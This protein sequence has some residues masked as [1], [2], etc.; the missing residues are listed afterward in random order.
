MNTP[1]NRRAFLKLAGL[2][3]LAAG[4]GACGPVQSWLATATPV[5]P[6][7]WPTKTLA[8]GAETVD[9]TDVFGAH[10]DLASTLMRD[11][12]PRLVKD[13]ATAEDWQ[14][15]PL[16]RLVGRDFYGSLTTALE[17]FNGEIFS[18]G[19]DYLISYYVRSAGG[20][21]VY[22]WMH[23]LD[24]LSAYG[25]GPK[26]ATEQVRRVWHVARATGPNRL[27]VVRD[28]ARP[29][30]EQ[31]EPTLFWLFQG[32][33]NPGWQID[34]RVGGFLVED[35]GASGEAAP[36]SGVAVMG[37]STTEGFSGGTDHPL[38][39]E[40]TTH[41]AARLN[42]PFYNRAYHGWTTADMRLA[43][44]QRITPLA[45][46]CRFCIVQ[47]GLND[48]ALGRSLT[49]MQAD[50]QW[51]WNQAEALGMLPIVATATPYNVIA[52]AGREDQR[53]ALNDW[54]RGT[55]VRVLDFDAVVRDPG[56]PSSL[57]RK[58]GWIGDGGHYDELAKQAIGEM[59]AGWEGWDFPQ[60]GPYPVG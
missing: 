17:T 8:P 48:I 18:A 19:H 53:Q 15:I 2:G 3:G 51:M 22:I 37:D 57:R 44:E 50:F 58:E 47:G 13:P 60:P 42:A 35:L 6:I 4:I 30:D 38:S 33:S 46:Y 27:A 40:W 43:W 23:P 41:A 25:H 36:R 28:P 20:E 21:D 10:M 52:N 7:P 49:D 45:Q 34:L 55:F 16:Q 56:D 9:H 26:L 59:V 54:L 12:P 11:N 1:F 24:G 32:A 5:T 14:G 29:P 31:S 39:H